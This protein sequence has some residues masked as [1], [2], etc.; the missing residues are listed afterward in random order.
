MPRNWSWGKKRDSGYRSKKEEELAE[1]LSTHDIGFQYESLKL[2]YQKPIR[3]GLCNECGK[4]NVVQKSSYTPD[5]VLENGTIIEYKGRLTRKD[6]TKLL[7]VLKCN[8]GIKLKL[9]FGS[10]NKLEKNNNKRYSQWATENGFDY[11]LGTPPRRW[12]RS[13]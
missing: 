10:D 5:F 11:A 4:S 7:S 3:K 13:V 8:P 12:L 2:D 6:R 1:W 9:L